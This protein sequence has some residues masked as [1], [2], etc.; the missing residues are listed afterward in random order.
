MR[1]STEDE[2]TYNKTQEGLYRD[3]EGSVPWMEEY[4][5]HKCALEGQKKK[6]KRKE[7]IAIDR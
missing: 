5:E 2:K 3:N 1:V 7:D 4:D 6:E